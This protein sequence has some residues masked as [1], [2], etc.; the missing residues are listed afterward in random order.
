MKK[1][2]KTI[3]QCAYIDI[4]QLLFTRWLEHYLCAKQLIQPFVTLEVAPQVVAISD[5][6]IDVHILVG[7]LLPTCAKYFPKRIAKMISRK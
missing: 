5:L 2:I 6:R 7:I 3:I 4:I 1:S